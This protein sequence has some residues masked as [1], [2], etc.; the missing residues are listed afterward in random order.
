MTECLTDYK[1]EELIDV[2]LW[3]K[4]GVYETRLCIQLFKKEKKCVIIV[5][6]VDL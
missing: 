1:A 5:Q 6:G 2:L 3:N 4:F